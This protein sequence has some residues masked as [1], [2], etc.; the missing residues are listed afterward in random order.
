MKSRATDSQWR[1]LGFCCVQ[2]EGQIETGSSS[3][4]S[5]LAARRPPSTVHRYLP[6]PNAR[7]TGSSP[8]RKN[9]S[10]AS[11][12]LWQSLVF[13]RL[14]KTVGRPTQNFLRRLHEFFA[15]LP[16]TSS[17]AWKRSTAASRGSHRL[18]RPAS[19][20]SNRF[21]PSGYPSACGCCYEYFES[22]CSGDSSVLANRCWFVSGDDTRANSGGTE[23]QGKMAH[24]SRPLA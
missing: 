12:G 23:G 18:W 7:G 5:E 9:W 11:T 20:P 4:Q 19:V 13:P 15:R 8:T 24:E 3:E 1:L 2:P 14:M 22:N 16:P 17:C 10:A 21:S 6:I